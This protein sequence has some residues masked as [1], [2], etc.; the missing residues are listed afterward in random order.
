MTDDE[1][2]RS[3]RVHQRVRDY[4]YRLSESTTETQTMISLLI[5]LRAWCKSRGVDWESV[6]VQADAYFDQRK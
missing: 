2:D 4:A 5:D 6:T 3:G 1:L